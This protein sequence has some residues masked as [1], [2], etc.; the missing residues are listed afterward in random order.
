MRG[1]Q[2]VVLFLCPVLLFG[3]GLLKVVRGFLSRFASH[4]WLH[5]R[6][7]H[8][9]GALPHQT[10]HVVYL[11]CFLLPILLLVLWILL[12][13]ENRVLKI[14]TLAGGSSLS[15]RQ[16]AVN[17]Y[18]YE[19][20]KELPFV[21]NV[22]VDASTTSD[23]SL[24]VQI[25][26][27]ISAA[28]QLD[29]LQ[30]C[31]QTRVREVVQSSFGV[32]KFVEPEILIEAVAVG[33]TPPSSQPNSIEKF[34]GTPLGREPV[35]AAASAMAVS[36]LEAESPAPDNLPGEP[37]DEAFNSA[38]FETIR[39]GVEH[40]PETPRKGEGELPTPAEPA[41]PTEADKAEGGSEQPK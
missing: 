14:A 9:V 34:D 30:Q 27:W 29:S 1:M 37:K 41:A 21:R 31:M 33:S 2:R 15:I 28:Q 19:C 16:S 10:F 11:L 38:F 12:R 17:R 6:V 22:R 35:V 25:R 18:L 7:E 23:G 20:L 24:A 3:L 4:S 32:Q 39:Q 26:V 40:N 13:R 5:M 8:W 36:S